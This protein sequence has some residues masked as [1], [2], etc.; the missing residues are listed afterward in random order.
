MSSWLALVTRKKELLRESRFR[1]VQRHVDSD[2]VHGSRWIP[3]QFQ[4]ITKAAE[5]RQQLY[6]GGL[7]SPLT[8][9]QFRAVLCGGEGSGDGVG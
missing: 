9:I 4:A 3:G 5:R 7:L 2:E 8:R 6:G 1:M